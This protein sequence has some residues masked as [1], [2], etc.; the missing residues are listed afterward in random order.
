MKKLAFTILLFNCIGIIYAQVPEI[1]PKYYIGQDSTLYWN[2][3]LPVYIK[4]SPTLQGE[5]V[6]LIS[7]EF[8]QYTNPVFLDT[9]GPN[10]IRTKYAVDKLTGEVKVPKTEVLFE[11]VS[12]GIA[13]TS[14]I[15]F[16]KAQVYSTGNKIYYG[17]GLEFE[18]NA[19][20]KYSG[21]ENIF[22]AV[23]DAPIK[24]F[25]GS[26]SISHEGDH[27][28]KYFATDNVGNAESIQTV[29]FT[30]DTSAPS[31]T[32]N[33]NGVAD[34][35][36]LAGTS[37]LY[38]TAVDPLSGVAGSSFR[39]DDQ[40]FSKYSGNKIDLANLEDGPHSIEYFAEDQVGNRS[41]T[42]KFDFYYDKLA[43]LTA[44]DIIGDKFLYL[45]KVYFSGRTK[46]KLT[47]IDNKI[48]VKEIKYSIDNGN[49]LTYEEPF[50]LPSVQGN[51][52]IKFYSVDRLSNQPSGA[53]EYKHN[54]NL[55]Y[56][57]LTG[58]DISHSIT[59]PSFKSANDV[60]IGPA[61]NI[62][63][64][65]E[66]HQSGLQ[67]LAYSIDGALAETKYDKPFQLNTNSGS[68]KIEMFGYDN[69]NNRNIN[70]IT[71]LYDANAPK[72]LPNFSVGAVGQVNDLSVYPAHM[73]LFLAATDE[74]VGN[75]KIY[76]Q[77]NSS[78]EQQYINPI[79]QWQ[80]GTL[81]KIKIRAIDK[82][83]NEATS[84]LSFR[85]ADK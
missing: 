44:S 15:S 71:V 66:D 32:H 9:E 13:P 74:M 69:V 84:E 31:I 27:T 23:D 26:Q 43:P 34:G 58:P 50:Y 79:S 12:D 73:T 67:Y 39:F 8:E 11:V 83:G 6:N 35:N 57:D 20:D 5:G 2:K 37:T 76:F 55:V 33:I 10:Y 1:K 38:L 46:M 75:D 4:L 25:T 63:L 54:I 36:T 28:I 56:L 30:V 51:H 24:S 80:K 47:A 82:V 72:I 68:H 61:S 52:T 14:Q 22:A 41:V 59:G 17:K 81:Y 64:V 29:G 16:K 7:K 85:I 21:I 60:F 65:G 45:D 42:F 48:G 3:K 40:P 19:N 62:R 70:Q 18:L 49:F 77:I 53:E 78:P